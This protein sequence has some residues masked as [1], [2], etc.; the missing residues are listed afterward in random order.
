MKAVSHAFTL[1]TSLNPT[2]TGLTS[3]PVKG[4]KT[5]DILTA[6]E[7]NRMLEL[8]SEGGGSGLEL[9]KCT[10]GGYMNMVTTS[11]LIYGETCIFGNGGTASNVQYSSWSCTKIPNP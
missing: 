1:A 9:W 10:C 11:N 6:G 8:V 7:W 2:D 3:E 5:G 4:K